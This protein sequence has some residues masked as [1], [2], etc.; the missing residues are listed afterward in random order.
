MEFYKIR[1]DVPVCT[2]CSE[3][4]WEGRYDVIVVGLGTAGAQCAI[5][6]ARHSMNV[7][8][9]EEL[10]SLGGMAAAG[11]ITEYYC[12]N[13]GGLY[14]E[15]DRQAAE[16]EN[17]PEWIPN[18]QGIGG[19][20]KH[21]AL[22]KNLAREN[23]SLLF[24]SVIT[25][26]W[27][28][29][30][31]II[32]VRV[33]DGL[34]RRHAYR[35]AYTIDCTGDGLLCTMAGC[36]MQWSQHILTPFQ[37][38]SNI[39]VILTEK[40]VRCRNVDSGYIDPQDPWDYSRG[41]LSSAGLP[42]FYPEDYAKEEPLLYNAPLLGVR[43]SRRIVGEENVTFENILM[44]TG[45]QNPA[46]FCYSNIDN[47]SRATAFESPLYQDWIA[48]AGLW[49]VYLKF[50]V[51]MG[52]LIP[53]GLEGILAA[54]RII[55]ADHDAACALRMKDE[56]YKSG[57][58]A[59]CL[60]YLS[61]RHGLPA[62]KIPYSELRCELMR[63][64][65]LKEGEHACALGYSGNDQLNPLCQPET[66][67]AL[68]ES[69]ASPAPGIALW[70]ARCHENFNPYDV[71][72]TKWL[73]SEQELL[74]YHSAI[75]LALGGRKACL[76][77]LREMILDKHGNT[78]QNSRNFRHPYAL[79]SI[80]LA[81]RLKLT[82]LADILYE[83]MASD[84]YADSTVL[85]PNELCADREDLRFQ[86][87]TYSLV[88]LLRISE[89]DPAL[90]KQVRKLARERLKSQPFRLSLGSAKICVNEAISDWLG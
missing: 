4:N 21:L 35:A 53:K 80:L 61:V 79:L 49:S 86:Y 74:R 63:S 71:V 43:E 46:F 10:T 39:R 8:G 69:L 50:P 54:G 57:E 45:V 90:Q 77:V 51:P 44:E 52:S 24:D 58:V 28:E 1:E 81:G 76:P 65:C 67:E 14:Q 42:N 22:Q 29:K 84:C 20:A 11:E 70:F 5:T 48:A 60:A 85:Q 56:M 23:V 87:F 30:N 17:V 33:L 3:P 78:L 83:I 72:L 82:E 18:A 40:G 89:N 59:A 16:L 47:H 75:A 12:G 19:W 7:L 36:D 13:K 41:I 66:E 88:S 26:V 34:G 32:G 55:S 68:R 2:P 62:G 37:P 38:F 9:I 31:R 15:I 64:G 25:G 73:E 27:R 6:A